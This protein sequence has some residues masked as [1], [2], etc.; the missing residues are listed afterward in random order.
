MNLPNIGNLMLI[1]EYTKKAMSDVADFLENNMYVGEK[2]F[3]SG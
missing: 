1:T 3:K 2:W